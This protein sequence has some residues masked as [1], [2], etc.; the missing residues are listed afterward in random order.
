M[1][2]QDGEK[3]TTYQITLIGAAL[4]RK[5]EA[6]DT[7][8]LSRVTDSTSTMKNYHARADGLL[9]KVTHRGASGQTISPNL[10]VE[11]FLD[12]YT[13]TRTIKV[14]STLQALKYK[15]TGIAARNLGDVQLHFQE[16]F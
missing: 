2:A 11:Q 12:R 3:R 10:R 6:K 1:P 5:G 14:G 16:R 15:V 8:S 7:Y 13:V 9:H 4:C